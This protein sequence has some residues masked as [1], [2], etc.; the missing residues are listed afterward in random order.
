MPRKPWS[1]LKGIRLARVL[2]ACILFG[3]CLDVLAAEPDYYARFEEVLKS[4]QGGFAEDASLVNTNT[5]VPISTNAP[6][7]L[8][9][10]M[11]RGE[12]CGVRLGMTMSDVVR[13]WGKPNQLYNCGI[14]PHF[15]YTGSGQYSGY[16]VTLIFS[17]NKVEVIYIR[18]GTLRNLR[19]EEKGLS[20]MADKEAIL[21]ALGPP[22]AHPPK[23]RIFD[24]GMVYYEGNV[25]TDFK[26]GNRQPN[27][28]KEP[29]YGL[30]YLVVR[31]VDGIANIPEPE[32]RGSTNASQ[33]T[34]EITNRPSSTDGPIR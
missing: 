9:A 25:R 11:S 13:I 14:G 8:S 5:P 31:F 22:L 6:I 3:L 20:G 26:F 27:R 21:S 18:P 7:S 12:L 32:F 17:S 29:K 2:L 28:S 16:G 23:V 15:Y 33:P 4:G 19:F 10:L 34:N 24:G 1:L 30:D